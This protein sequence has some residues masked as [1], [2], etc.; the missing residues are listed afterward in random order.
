MSNSIEGVVRESA[1]EQVTMHKVEG[2]VW[3]VLGALFFLLAVFVHGKDDEQT[4][5]VVA[6]VLGA[7]MVVGGVAYINVMSAAWRRSSRC[8]CIVVRS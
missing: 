8:F 2:G 6:G 7:M 5:R 4:M 3:I 1:R